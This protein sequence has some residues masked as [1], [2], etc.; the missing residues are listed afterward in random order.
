MH[1][2]LANERLDAETIHCGSRAAAFDFLRG[3][4]GGVAACG[5]SMGVFTINPVIPNSVNSGAL[6]SAP[7]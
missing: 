3:I 5:H 2:V 4:S 7:E 6:S 1:E